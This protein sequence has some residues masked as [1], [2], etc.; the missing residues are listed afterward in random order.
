MCQST[1]TRTDS[2]KDLGVFLN[3]KL[4]SHNHVNHIF[5]LCTK[6]QRPVRSITSNFSCLDVRPGFTLHMNL[7]IPNALCR[8]ACRLA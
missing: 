2:T 5:S 1:T 8:T 7:N 3:A 6:L 4:Y